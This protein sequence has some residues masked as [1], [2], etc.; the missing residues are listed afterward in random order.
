[1]A[2]EKTDAVNTPANIPQATKR[3]LLAS[4]LLP[5]LLALRVFDGKPVPGGLA[6]HIAVKAA[7][8]VFP[9][10]DISRDPPRVRPMPLAPNVEPW[11]LDLGRLEEG[12]ATVHRCTAAIVAALRT[13][14]TLESRRALAEKLGPFVENVRVDPDGAFYLEVIAPLAGTPSAADPRD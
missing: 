11:M 9:D 2:D 6:R 12:D 14:N 3:G 7:E 1:M 13:C 10:L 5:G 8:A 4:S